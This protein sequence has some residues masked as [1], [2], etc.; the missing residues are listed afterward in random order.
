MML[1]IGVPLYELN[2]AVML[3]E[4]GIGEGDGRVRV[5]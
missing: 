2:K 4:G 5:M 3:E 1:G